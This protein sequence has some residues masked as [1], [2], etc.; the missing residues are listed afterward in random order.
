LPYALAIGVPESR[1]WNLTYRAYKPYIKAHELRNEQ[2]NQ[3]MWLQG[4]YNARAVAVGMGSKDKRTK[5]EIE[6]FKEPIQ[7]REK[8]K[9]DAEKQLDAEK[10]RQKIIADLTGW[11]KNWKKLKK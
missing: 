10:A 2:R 3:E 1:F 11:E 4:L 6:Y 7:L 5:K 9:T 8:P